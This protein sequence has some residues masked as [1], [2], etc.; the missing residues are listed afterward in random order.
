LRVVM[1]LRPIPETARVRDVA[2][3]TLLLTT[4]DPAQALKVLDEQ[5]IHHLWLEGG[6]TVAAAFLGAG[7]VDEVIAYLAPALLGAGAPA[8]GDLGIRNI[9]QALRLVPHEVTTIGPD[10]RIRAT[11]AAPGREGR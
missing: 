2:A 9:D 4:H 7:L 10:I 6:P 1:G 11:I 8:L 5:E 3:P